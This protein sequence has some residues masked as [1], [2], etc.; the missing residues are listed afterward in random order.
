MVS[1]AADKASVWRMFA[2]A[3]TSLSLLILWMAAV[4]AV[5]SIQSDFGFR[6]AWTRILGAD[7][8]RPE[9]AMVYLLIVGCLGLTT[10]VAVRIWHGLRTTALTG[11]NAKTLRH[12]VV[13]TA[14]AGIVAGVLAIGSSALAND[15]ERNVDVGVWL[16]WLPFA[17]LALVAQT[18]AEEVFFRGYLQTHLAARFKSTLIWLLVPAILFGFA[19]FSPNMPGR[20]AFAYFSFAALFGLLAGDLTARTG[21][22]GAAWG[23]HFAN[24]SIAVLFFTIDGSITGL[25]LYK[26]SV[27]LND[28]GA[29]GPWI[30]IDLVA[31]VLIWWCIRRVLD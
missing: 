13:A 3:I 2:V 10:L 25:G 18:G 4:A 23:F 28:I 22:I 20:V 24:N 27:G 15:F 29:I 7:A 31:M 6:I 17:A 21:S 12:F 8:S 16:F 5:L 1:A 14:V 11:P 26:T 19:H 9:G 30:V